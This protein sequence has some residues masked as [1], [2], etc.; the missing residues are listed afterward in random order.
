MPFSM[1]LRTLTVSLVSALTYLRER[2]APLFAR[3]PESLGKVFNLD[4]PLVYILSKGH[5]A[6]PDSPSLALWLGAGGGSS[7]TDSLRSS[8]RTGP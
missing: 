8:P 2:Q 1:R 4:R 6:P 7:P 5:V 3:L